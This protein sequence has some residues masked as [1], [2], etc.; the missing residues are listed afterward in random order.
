MAM[1][2]S[3]KAVF[4]AVEAIDSESKTIM[5]PPQPT[6]QIVPSTLL[7]A[8]SIETRTAD[9]TPVSVVDPEHMNMPERPMLSKAIVVAAAGHGSSSPTVP[10]NRIS[11]ASVSVA[12][13][14][15]FCESVHSAVRTHSPC[16]V[17]PWSGNGEGGATTTETK[18]PWYAD[19]PKQWLFNC[20]QN[21]HWPLP[22]F[23]C[24]TSSGDSVLSAISTRKATRGRGCGADL[25]SRVSPRSIGVGNGPSSICIGGAVTCRMAWPVEVLRRLQTASATRRDGAWG[26]ASAAC[27]VVVVSGLTRK[28]AET[29]AAIEVPKETIVRGRE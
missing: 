8:D 9:K 5:S 12:S 16:H 22:E 2:L 4:G 3:N 23:I 25:S 27:G 11:A 26:N 10:S 29:A 13:A 19:T 6:F 7:S 14:V 20:C 21:N 1:G 15:R 17:V 24:E 18:R 28:D